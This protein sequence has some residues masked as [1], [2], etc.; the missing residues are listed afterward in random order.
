MCPLP[1]TSLFSC[2]AH[3]H[4]SELMKIRS[5]SCNARLEMFGCFLPGA[6][7]FFFVS[8]KNLDYYYFC[9]RRNI[10]NISL[11]SVHFLLL[12]STVGTA[13]KS[14]IKGSRNPI[15]TFFNVFL[16]QVR[17]IVGVAIRQ[18]N[19]MISNVVRDCVTRKCRRALPTPSHTRQTA[20]VSKKIQ[21]SS[22]QHS[23]HR[24][25]HSKKRARCLRQTA[26]FKENKD[27]LSITTRQSSKEGR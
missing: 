25:P 23:S 8:S 2:C 18:K 6:W 12:H 17:T 11:S 4:G 24:H 22:H 7:S 27:D 3:C 19:E 15:A 21:T 16:S 14:L 13:C 5:I 9:Y 1:L 10:M 26:L 20:R